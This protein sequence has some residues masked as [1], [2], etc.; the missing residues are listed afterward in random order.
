MEHSRRYSGTNSLG[1]TTRTQEKETQ[2]T[3]TFNQQ[4]KSSQKKC[5][6]CRYKKPNIPITNLSNHQLSRD[7][8]T[9]LSKGLNFIPTPKRDHPTKCY[10]THYYLTGKSGS[11]TTFVMIKTKTMKPQNKQIIKY[12]IQAQVGPLQ[13]DRIHSQIHT[14]I[15]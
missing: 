1:N 8:I 4:H 13:V 7:E 12:Y 3:S 11:N 15:L 9:L 14:G 10:R 6:N 2:T 5:K